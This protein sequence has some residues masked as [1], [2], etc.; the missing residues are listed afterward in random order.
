MNFREIYLDR[1]HF[2]QLFNIEDET[3]LHYIHQNFKLQF[4]NDVVLASY[5]QSD[6]FSASVISRVRYHHY[7]QL[8]SSNNVR[9]VKGLLHHDRS[10][11]VKAFSSM[12]V[13]P[14]EKAQFL[15]EFINVSK[16]ALYR[17]RNRFHQQFEEFKAAFIE[18][19]K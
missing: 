11:M 10:G 3:T 9:I 14:E 18:T 2:K 8:I 7:S 13:Y 1:S 15:T 4:I 5:L 12:E 16:A 6:E 17:V 19:C